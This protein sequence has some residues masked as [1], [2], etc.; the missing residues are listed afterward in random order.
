MCDWLTEIWWEVWRAVT[1][2]YEWVLL[3]SEALP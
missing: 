3:G 1:G 2:D